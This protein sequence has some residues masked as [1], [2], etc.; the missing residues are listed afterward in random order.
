MVSIDSPSIRLIV[1]CLSII[2]S[3]NSK[4]FQNV[5]NAFEYMKYVKRESNK[6][7][8]LMKQLQNKENDQNT[9]T[10]IVLLINELLVGSEDEEQ[11]KIQ[12]QF[13]HLNL[14]AICDVF[15]HHLT[16]R[17]CQKLPNFNIW[18]IKLK[19]SGN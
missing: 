4:G 14:L 6:F 1:L 9:Q 11:Y 8:N 3:S 12:V 7:E 13:N 5:S 17:N 15:L 18:T 19:F 10:N 16:F 2:C